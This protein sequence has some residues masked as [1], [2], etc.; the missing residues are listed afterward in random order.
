MLTGKR[1]KAVVKN[2]RWVEK[3]ETAK[4]II[5][6]VMEAETATPEQIDTLH[7]LFAWEADESRYTVIS[8]DAEVKTDVVA[9]IDMLR[10][11]GIY[12]LSKGA[13]EEY[14]PDDVTLNCSKSE[15]ALK[16][17]QTVT[18]QN[19]AKALSLPLAEARPTELEEIFQ[20]IFEQ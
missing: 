16:V 13:I 10:T 14:Y 1:V 3:Y 8:T 4:D 2:P 12:I 19:L 6:A 18:S 7:E 11:E 5:H 9:L 20:H 15:R 17:I